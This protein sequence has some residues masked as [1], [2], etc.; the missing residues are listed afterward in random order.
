MSLKPSFN[1]DDNNSGVTATRNLFE[2]AVLTSHGLKLADVR[3][4]GQKA[5][6]TFRDPKAAK[7]LAAH[8]NGELEV[9]SRMFV[10]EINAARDIA[11]AL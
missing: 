8:R 5:V 2:V 7:I 11:F 10:N 4:E 1:L 3:R 9:N 6:F